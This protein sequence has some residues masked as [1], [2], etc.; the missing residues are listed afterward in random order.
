MRN[1]MLRCKEY[2]EQG[3]PTVEIAQR[4]GISR[5]TVYLYHKKMF[6]TQKYNQRK[7]EQF[8]KL[9]DGG[10]TIA[11]IS[12]FLRFTKGSVQRFITKYTNERKSV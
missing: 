12:Y 8:K 11:E 2:L 3:L 6:P 1:K 10:F 5:Q 7:Y 9:F 4:L